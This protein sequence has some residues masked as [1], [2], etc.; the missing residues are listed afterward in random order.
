M[1]LDYGLLQ[2][3]GEG[4]T[5]GVESYQR[6]SELG[7]K[8]RE[9]ENLAKYRE[10]QEKRQRLMDL[11]K[12]A[13]AG[14]EEDPESG[15][16][17]RTAQAEQE[18]KQDREAKLRKQQLEE[19][20]GLAKIEGEYGFK[21]KF[22][23]DGQI[24]GYTEPEGGAF[25]SRR[26]LDT[27]VKQNQI[28]RDQQ[29]MEDR[30][31]L[32]ARENI[33]IQ[34]DLAGKGLVPIYGQ[35]GTVTGIDPK[36]IEEARRQKALEAEANQKFK[37]FQ[38]RKLQ[39]ESSLQEPKMQMQKEA[40]QEANAL[41]KESLRLS[42][43]AQKSRDENERARLTQ[44]AEISKKN[45]ELKLREASEKS[46]KVSKPS[47]AEQNF[48]GFA[49]KAQKAHEIANEIENSSSD[50]ASISFSA[51]RFGSNLPII[52][53][54]IRKKI[55]ENVQKY[56][57]AQKSFVNAVLRPESGAAI[58]PTEFEEAR[59]QY[60]PQPGDSKATVE[61]K[62]QLRLEKVAALRQQGA[63]ATQGMEEAY[64]SVSKPSGLIKKASPANSGPHGPSVMQNGVKFIWNG[65]E[66]VP[67]K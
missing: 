9:Q 43:Q 60:F 66:Y 57:N 4:L 30:K 6:Q 33:K 7:M 48:A 55:P 24:I 61:Q 34:S 21:P 19:Y 20:Q 3:I 15:G 54:L 53:G 40:L 50:P 38:A 36:S 62:R 11:A 63:G 23:S 56:E 52:G 47:A 5:K 41:R 31:A 14:F 2:G 18:K 45:Y 42:E 46:A 64:G 44:Q 49:L 51:E 32:A 16:V 8:K 58:S 35:G 27:M 17:R 37:S 12:M 67:G 22:S 1:G 13:E 10:L 39:I 25:L 29:M 59:K 26:Q 28:L 65:S